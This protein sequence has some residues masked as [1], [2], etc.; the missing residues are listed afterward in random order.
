MHILICLSIFF[1]VLGGDDE[2]I[3]KLDETSNPPEK[4]DLLV[5]S[6][7]EDKYELKEILIGNFQ[8]DIQ[9]DA[10]LLRVNSDF[11]SD[12]SSKF[13]LSCANMDK[14]G[15]VVQND[16]LSRKGVPVDLQYGDILGDGRDEVVVHW[17]DENSHELIGLLGS[18]GLMESVFPVYEV[19][20]DRRE[21]IALADMDGD[22]SREIVVSSFRT[23]LSPKNEIDKIIVYFI[24]PEGVTEESYALIPVPV[25]ESMVDDIDSDGKD[26]IVTLREVKDG[27]NSQAI[28]SISRQDDGS[29]VEKPVTKGNSLKLVQSPSSIDYL[30]FMRKETKAG[31]YFNEIVALEYLDGGFKEVS[32]CRLMPQGLAFGMGWGRFNSPDEECL[33][34]ITDEA[35]HSR[36]WLTLYT[37]IIK[38]KFGNGLELISNDDFQPFGSSVAGYD[39]D[40]D[41]VEE[42]VYIGFGGKAYGYNT[43][44]RERKYLYVK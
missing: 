6:S 14:R 38:G 30:F 43:V 33:A 16:I 4:T 35:M 2:S 8:S 34:V 25:L 32:K 15:F 11:S 37:P 22:G 41:G 12:K 19:P 39:F 36:R 17:T 42:I 20:D 10:I 28:W 29:Y 5:E 27:S 21:E 13:I 9:E 31:Q 3:F 1:L 40:G 26:E 44:T 23:E 24:T 18:E 7:L